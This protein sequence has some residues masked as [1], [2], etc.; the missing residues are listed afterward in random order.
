M[1]QSPQIKNDKK[2][3]LDIFSQFNKMDVAV[4]L[5]IC[6]SHNAHET[7]YDETGDC[8]VVPPRND[9]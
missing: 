4:F 6:I 1:D 3:E 8:R 9:G 2:P 7:A 5:L